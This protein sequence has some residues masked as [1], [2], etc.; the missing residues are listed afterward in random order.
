MKSWTPK[1]EEVPPYAYQAFESL[2]VGVFWYTDSGRLLYCNPAGYSLFSN[3]ENELTHVHD[4]FESVPFA[5]Q[6]QELPP[7]LYL[8]SAFASMRSNEFFSY[9]VSSFTRTQNKRKVR[10]N[11]LLIESSMSL[12]KKEQS[13]HEYNE[14][15]LF[16]KSSHGTQNPL[17]YISLLLPKIAH[18]IK[19]PLACI[20]SMAELLGEALEDT[21]HAHEIELI[22][23]EIVRLRF[24]IDRMILANQDLRNVSQE[25][26]I[27]E[28]V[29]R[30]IKLA[31][32]RATLLGTRLHFEKPDHPIWAFVHP[33]LFHMA[34]LNLVN[35]AIE[36]CLDKGEIFL[37]VGEHDDNLWFS[38]VDTG[39]GMSSDVIEHAT[40]PFFSTKRGG[41]GIGLAL[42]SQLIKKS[43]GSFE[44]WSREGRGTRVS[45]SIPSV[46]G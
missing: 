4:L 40:E 32:T 16:P 18:E 36:A 22:L 21:S 27:V 45:I 46:S 39:C 3:T 23:Q 12:Q 7:Y 35:N 34:L 9:S 2:Q 17:V 42:T 10:V 19:N 24:V 31:S 29:E 43:G 38:V 30:V 6:S 5:E 26:N 1:D 20:Q 37:S 8:K 15:Q 25:S 33:E 14:V 41:T 28:V 44:L 13:V 11:V